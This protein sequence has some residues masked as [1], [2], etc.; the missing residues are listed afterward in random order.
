MIVEG[1]RIADTIV[2]GLKEAIRKDGLAPRLV[3]FTCAPTFETKKY[4]ALKEKKARE[5]G[6]TVDIVECT[7]DSTTQDIVDGIEASAKNA[8]G[9][10]VQLPL[11]NTI[12]RDQVI[13]AIPPSHDVDALNPRTTDMI[14]PVVG[15]FREIL[16]TYSI[17]PRGKNVV[18]I[19]KGRL[20]GM[21]AERWFIAQG[22]DVHVV[23]R[24]TPRIEEHTQKADIVVCGAGTP[25]ML[26]PHMVENGV[27]ILDAG[28]SE[29]GGEL[30]GDADPRCEEKASLFT[31][32][33]GG[34]G[35]LT[36][37]ML[38]SNVVDCARKKRPVL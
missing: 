34:I 29:D 38:L 1:K 4:L 31:P 11:P 28:T 13:K 12:D 16:R 20:V 7:R 35:P 26:L 17:D 9:I 2:A 6:I 24:N 19:G 23:T 25:G 14:S 22:A 10:I 21:P 5:A 36:I 27:V 32:V 8:D 15:A 18:I 3:V 33:P 30:R 37:A